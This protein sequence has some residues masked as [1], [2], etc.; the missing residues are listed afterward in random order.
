MKQKN[1]KV[2]SIGEIDIDQLIRDGEAKHKMLKEAAESQ[3]DMMR[4]DT[5][6]DFTLESIDMF[7][8]QEKDFREEKKKVQEI[9]LEQE[10]KRLE[11][12]ASVHLPRNRR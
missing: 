6:F 2:T 3:V 10:A 5:S 8:F 4:S 12:K 9:M 1:E 7:R 11:N